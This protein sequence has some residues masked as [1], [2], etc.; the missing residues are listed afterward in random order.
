MKSP[1][2]R[3]TDS[4]NLYSIEMVERITRVSK[5]RILV[6]QRHGI[7]SAISPRGKPRFDDEAVHKLRRISRLL[8][9]YGVNEKGAVVLSSLLDEVERLREEIRFLRR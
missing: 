9:E 2:K 7:I 6:Y 5:D 1:P 3:L 8:S 4:G